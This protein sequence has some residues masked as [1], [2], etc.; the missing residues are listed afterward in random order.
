[1]LIKVM[2]QN[3]E[4]GT[5]NPF[6]LD[7]L[8]AS[9]KIKKF[10]RSE[11]WATIGIDPIRGTGGHYKGPERRIELLKDGDKTK[12]Q[13]IHE[14]KELRQ[15]ISEFEI[16]EAQRKKAEDLLRI[17]E[18]E[19]KKAYEKLKVSE[20]RYRRLFETAQDG[21]LLLDADTGQITDV[22]PF[23]TEMLGYSHRELLNKKLWEIGLF[24]DIVSS[25][26]AF[27]KLQT[28]GYIRYEDLP[29]ETKDGRDIEVEFV[30]NV[31]L[32]NGKKVIQCN[33]RDITDRKR[34]EEEI[35]K[36]ATKDILTG[37]YNRRKFKEIIRIEIERVKRYNQPLSIVMFDID[38]FKKINDRYGHSDGDYVLKTIAVIIKKNI[39]KID[40]LFRWGGEE[41]L[42]LSSETQLNNAHELAERIRKAIAR[43]KFKNIGKVTA[44]FGVTEFKK[45]DTQDRFI[46]RADDAMYKAKKKGRNR[47]E[48]K[49]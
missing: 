35:K 17:I 24:K 41:F 11:G 27:S 49:V 39:R 9:G 20:T 6:L 22:N 31:Y 13:L 10:L 3:N 26:A 12:E 16:S 34:M 2:Y 21:I 32:V 40:Y 7:E 36:L 23:L 47:V 44:S 28:K 45:R 15:Q 1:M 25:K 33:I 14:M 48:V 42:I 19:G 5:V 30:S 38:H 46:K 29:I 8:I 4:Y 37:F 43:Y 18:A